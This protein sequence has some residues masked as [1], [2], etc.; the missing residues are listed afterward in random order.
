M[1]ALFL[2]G[3]PGHSTVM[4]YNATRFWREACDLVGVSIKESNDVQSMG[5]RG[6][7]MSVGQP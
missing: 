6:R 3:R 2:V 7:G 1:K 4:R 5:S